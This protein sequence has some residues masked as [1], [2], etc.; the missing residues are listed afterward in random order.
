MQEH[1][2]PL[3]ILGTGP[4]AEEVADLVSEIPIF[5]LVGFVEN[6]EPDK[7]GRT[8]LDKPIIW[9]EDLPQYIEQCFG[10]C[11]IGS[12]RRNGFIERATQLGLRFTT[13]IHPTAR[14]APTVQVGVGCIVSVGVIIAA[15]ARVGRHVF[16][17]RGSLIGH[18]T[19]IGDYVTVSP[20]ANIAGKVT[21]GSGSYIA[22][23][24]TIIDNLN[25]GANAVVGAGAVVTSDVPASV[26]VVG[27]PARI[28][29][30][31][32]EGL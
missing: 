21:I 14:I 24:A 31:N 9:I 25:V 20:G 11:A 17:N 28:V 6:M 8:L 13:V 1:S 3:V 18:H 29:K 10:V 26:Q 5:N 22:M 32:I 2:V 27:V 23:S 30:H 12:T 16:L 7:A 15:Q 4:L 19:D